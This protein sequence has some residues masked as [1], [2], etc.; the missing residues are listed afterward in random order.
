[1]ATPEVLGLRHFGGCAV[2]AD[3]CG[4]LRLVVFLLLLV[5]N[6]SAAAF[7]RR[8]RR[9][10][11]GNAILAAAPSWGLR[12]FSGFAVNVVATPEVLQ[13][14]HFGGCAVLAVAPFWRLRRTDGLLWLFSN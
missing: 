12:R 9:H 8:G 4:Y 3:F 1:M 7:W 11:D 10:F 13:L 14:R 6:F 5:F 2:L